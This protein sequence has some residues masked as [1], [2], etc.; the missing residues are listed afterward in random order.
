MKKKVNIDRPKISSEEI[1]SRKDFG[2]L[3][4]N[5]KPPVKPFYKTVW[6]MS[7][8][9]A[10][11]GV[12][13]IAGIYL[14]K[15]TSSEGTKKDKTETVQKDYTYQPGKDTAVRD[16]PFINRPLA[17]V[18][19]QYSSYK[20]SAE[21]GGEFT[22]GSGSKIR[23]PKNA[24]AGKSGEQL[25]GEVEI[26][27]R[28][29]R[30]PVDIFVSGIP[31]T[32][33]SAGVQRHFESAG[34]IEMYAFKD[35]QVVKLSE[36]KAIDVQMASSHDGS[37]YNLYYLDTTAKKWTYLGKDNIMKKLVEDKKDIY[38]LKDTARPVQSLKDISSEQYTGAQLKQV[39]IPEQKK[40]DEKSAQLQVCQ[41]DIV[42]LQQTKPV[43]PRLADSKKF[44]FKV[45]VDPKEFP[46]MAI[47]K[48]ILFQVSDENKNFNP[49]WYN[50]IWNEVQLSDG[51]K[52]GENYQIKLVKNQESVNVIVYPVFEGENYE[53]AMT[54]FKG[55]FAEYNTKLEQK[56]AEEKKLKEEFDKAMTLLKKKTEEQRAKLAEEMKKQQELYEKE[57][58]AQYANMD[59]SQKVM[60]EFQ[61]H[62]FGVYN[63]DCPNA[64]PAQ[65][66]VKAV[67]VDDK[68][69]ELNLYTVYL[70]DMRRNAMFTYSMEK[71]ANFGYNP[72]SEN[73]IFG[74]YNGRLAIVRNEN[75]LSAESVQGKKV[76]KMEIAA[77]DFKSV[78]EVKKFLNL[79][80]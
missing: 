66:V 49:S 57:L 46:E 45:E 12:L 64:Y 77:Q 80:T 7:G 31:M 34:M 9:A 71:F 20:V 69:R 51:P 18:D 59:N 35:G 70:A 28:E 42:K 72:K 61:V 22:Y 79:K 13:A 74:T 36:G 5:L 60:R 26:R 30:D 33:D 52:K 47:Y 75:I 41:N 16:L 1:A 54:G 14:A 56:H 67:F 58:E 40:A 63:C 24:F 3:L 68:Q 44:R 39:V 38:A 32:Y 17:D 23:V 43:V 19:V 2:S 4:K 48:N 29:L 6:F 78:D 15:Q 27:Y 10:T 25:R 65:S 37:R 76:F 11:V 73:M 55:K 62:G 21:K 53:K 50:V 8:I